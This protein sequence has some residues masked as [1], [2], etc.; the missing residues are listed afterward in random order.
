MNQKAA[1]NVLTKA[2]RTNVVTSAAMFVATSIPVTIKE[3]LA[4][5]SG[6][7]YAEKLTSNS[8]GIEGGW[9]A[10]PQVQ[11]LALQ[12]SLELEPL[13]SVLLEVS[14]VASEPHLPCAKQPY[15][16]KRISN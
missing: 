13:S 15:S 9:V 12:Y 10:H 4:K 7:D 11:P 16:S 5:M 14:V 2:T 6:A 3:C 1:V 8:A